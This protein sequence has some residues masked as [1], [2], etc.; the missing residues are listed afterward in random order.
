MTQ[1]EVLQGFKSTLR[2]WRQWRKK[3][4]NSNLLTGVKSIAQ[5]AARAEKFRALN[6][7][8]KPLMMSAEQIDNATIKNSAKSLEEKLFYQKWWED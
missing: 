6:L 2:Q 1:A 3:F 7:Y 8:S 5:N 4:Q